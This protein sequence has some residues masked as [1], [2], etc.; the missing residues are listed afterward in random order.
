MLT[1][2]DDDENVFEGIR[3]GALGYLLE[4]ASGEELAAAV[5]TVA[6]GGALIESSVARR[7]MA[8]FARLSSPSQGETKR[9][10][11]PLSE[12]ELEILKLLAQGLAKFLNLPFSQCPNLLIP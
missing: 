5:R 1:T 2:F 12:R 10:N 7:V 8:E 4:A 9:L 6:R 11:D 3:A